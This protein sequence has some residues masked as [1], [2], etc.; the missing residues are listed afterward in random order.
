M[1]RIVHGVVIAIADWWTSRAQQD[2]HASWSVYPDDL[3]SSEHE[4]CDANHPATDDAE[5]T[6]EAEDDAEDH[7]GQRQV[8]RREA[9]ISRAP[10]R[11][12]GWQRWYRFMPL[13]VSDTQ[14]LAC[15]LQ[16]NLAKS[17]SRMK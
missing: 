10:H 4:D 16:G 8:L 5:D 9:W 1:R 15:V 14:T 12:E 2:P 13:D 17:F 7:A 11:K 3:I 6:F